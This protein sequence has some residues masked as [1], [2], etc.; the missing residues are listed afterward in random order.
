ML[1]SAFSSLLLFN[2]IFVVVLDLGDNLTGEAELEVDTAN[3]PAAYYDFC[4]PIY[5][6]N[7]ARMQMDINRI[8][9]KAA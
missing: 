2:L 3:I 9:N 8:F 7:L 1:V 5:H 4:L 6:G